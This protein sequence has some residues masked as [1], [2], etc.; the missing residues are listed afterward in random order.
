[1]ASLSRIY[2][3]SSKTSTYKP[4]RRR[5]G[6][7]RQLP[8]TSGR[9][10]PERY[11]LEPVPGSFMPLDAQAHWDWRNPLNIIPAVILL[12]VIAALAGM[13]F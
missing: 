8:A 4:R 11:A 5:G 12:F 6:R 3:E 9:A 13:L 10:M 7:P 1:M 2:T